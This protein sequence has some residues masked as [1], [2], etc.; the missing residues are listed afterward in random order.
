MAV[1]GEY[2]RVDGRRQIADVVRLGKL[3]TIEM[4]FRGAWSTRAL[5]HALYLAATAIAARR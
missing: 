5:R 2:G 3:L 1:I 4:L